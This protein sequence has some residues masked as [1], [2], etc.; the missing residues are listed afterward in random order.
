MAEAR[1]LRCCIA[2][3]IHHC[4]TFATNAIRDR[5][6]AKTGLI[7]TEGFPAIFSKS[8]SARLRLSRL[9]EMVIP[10]PSRPGAVALAFESAS[11]LDHR[12]EGGFAR[13]IQ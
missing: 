13:P 9:Y 7:T 5:R 11:A 3:I 4:T 12:G 6:G 2:E 10:P 8:E 1:S